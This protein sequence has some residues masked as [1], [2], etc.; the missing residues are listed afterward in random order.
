MSRRSTLALAIGA[1]LGVSVAV[2]LVASLDG[3]SSVADQGSI[4]AASRPEES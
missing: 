4:V 1:V 3:G 2:A